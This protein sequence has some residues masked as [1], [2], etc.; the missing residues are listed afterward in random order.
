[1][2]LEAA[3]RMGMPLVLARGLAMELFRLFSKGPGD[4]PLRCIR[5]LPGTI[6]VSVVCMMV[7]LPGSMLLHVRRRDR[8]VRRLC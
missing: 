7:V 2:A 4:R 5:G 3:H 1:M 8:V 6:T